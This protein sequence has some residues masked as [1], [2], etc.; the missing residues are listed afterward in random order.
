MLYC[1]LFSQTLVLNKK[2]I[3]PFSVAYVY[4]STGLIVLL[5][6]HLWRT[7]VE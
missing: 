5:Q 6:I 4:C 3:N 2:L 7:M 1:S